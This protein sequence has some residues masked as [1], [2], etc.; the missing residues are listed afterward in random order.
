MTEQNQSRFEFVTV[1]SARA[2][3]LLNGCTPKIEGSSKPA[4]RAVQEVTAGLVQGTHGVD[5]ES[6]EG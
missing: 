2:K 6:Q 5:P 4:R 3:Q 1:A